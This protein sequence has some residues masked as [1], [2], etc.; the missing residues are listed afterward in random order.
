MK[1]AEPLE[2]GVDEVR[3]GDG[4]EIINFRLERVQELRRIFG[5]D[6]RDVCSLF[7]NF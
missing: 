2:P 5:G 3:G 7:G 6:W 1:V 4:V